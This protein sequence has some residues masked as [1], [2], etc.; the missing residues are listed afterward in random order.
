LLVED[1]D[2]RREAFAGLEEQHGHHSPA[3]PRTAHTA[4]TQFSP[5]RVHL[6]KRPNTK[7]EDELDF[8]KNEV[9]SLKLELY[10]LKKR[11]QKLEAA[12]KRHAAAVN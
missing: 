7:V 1:N 11:I 8:L 5:R 2:H 6:M 9:A 12:R 10:N 4:T 3:A